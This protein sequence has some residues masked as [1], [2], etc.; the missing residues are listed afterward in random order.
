MNLLSFGGDKE[1]PS[2]IRNSS[3]DGRR[4]SE[5]PFSLFKKNVPFWPNLISVDK[6]E[7]GRYRDVRS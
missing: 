5:A 3:N 1:A 2:L 6:T 4:G 7:G